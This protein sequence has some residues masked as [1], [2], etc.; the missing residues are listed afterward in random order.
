MAEDG[1][2]GSEGKGNLDGDKETLHKRLESRMFGMLGKMKP[3]GS[4]GDKGEPSKPPGGGGDQTPA[5]VVKEEQPAPTSGT[6]AAD[7]PGDSKPKDEGT[8]AAA[9][10]TPRQPEAPKDGAAEEPQA[11]EEQAPKEPEASP[12]GSE[13]APKDAPAGEKPKE[14]DAAADPP[15]EGEGGAGEAKPA[16]G[17]PAPGDAAAGKAEPA[18]EEKKA[19]DAGGA[20]AGKDSE[21]AEPA[22]DDGAAPKGKEE[23][24]QEPAKKKPAGKE[25]PS[26]D[27]G[28]KDAGKP[29]ETLEQLTTQK[30]EIE[31]L[32][33]SIEDSYR[34]ATLPDSAYH[35]VKDKNEK[36]LEEINAK[37]EKLG[38]KVTAN[39]PAGKES[40]GDEDLESIQKK[41]EEQAGGETAAKPA[42]AEP[43]T[44][45]ASA[46]PAEEKKDAG[47]AKAEALIKLLEEKI[48]ERLKGV[49][50]SASVEVTD[51]RL[52][53]V[54]SRLDALETLAKDTK[55]VSDK[56]TAT[57]GGYDKQFTSMKTE[58]EKVKAL[59]DS[60]KEAKNL[61]DE[62]IQRMTESFA[63]IRSIVY[64]REA[65]SKDQD[66]LL[67]KLK[68]TVSQIDSARILREFTTR[69][70]QLRDVNTRLER[71]ERSGKMTAEGLNKIKGLMTDIGSLEN[72]V[73]ASKH[74]GEKL[75]K[76]QEIEER[77]KAR[78]SKLDS[79]YVDMKKKIDEFNEYKVKQ[80]KL[81][82]MSDDMVK[83]VEELTR[84]L[85]DYA[86]KA[87]ITSV[88]DEL[89]IVR[90][91]AKS[92]AAVKAPV[93]Q[94]DSPEVAKLKAEKGE[95]E[96][97][98]ESLQENFNAKA[99]SE[100]EFN[101]AKEKN[102][103][104]LVQLEKQIKAAS[105]KAPGAAGAAG[106]EGRDHKRVMLLAKLRESYENGEI[107]RTA[108]EKSRKLLVKK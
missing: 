47:T 11:Q 99:M 75:E 72:I 8:T 74:V 28:E 57:V 36:K 41:L 84:R 55:A 92:A 4:P 62:K 40:A 108:Y 97:M 98:I 24:E 21:A 38:G 45:A 43:A 18:P 89:K 105:Q 42:S 19:G 37:I 107:S 44:P 23:G 56:T 83:N 61:T 3:G 80:D 46:A 86:T 77:Q 20:Q 30:E 9:E 26:N 16:A 10:E 65:S 69:D 48:E 90:E 95:I 67:D 14:A 94:A 6:P 25:K 66:V 17:E 85:A 82:G 33:S 59:V 51:K 63:E 32:L 101:S 81:T 22:G 13:A 39:E 1:E 31:S 2:K 78:T 5:A 102:M 12:A 106:G 104:K 87:D 34:D 64:Q 79:I 50:A 70:E 96:A 58:V 88:K 68:D 53:K 91:T 7:S 73:K 54:D 27:A 29:K 35:E 76:I 49:I 93:V 100:A 15:K 60:A 71:L 52:R 103:Q